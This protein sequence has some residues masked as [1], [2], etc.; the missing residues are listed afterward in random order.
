MKKAILILLVVSLS[1]LFFGCE[2]K[3]QDITGW[4][5]FVEDFIAI[6]FELNPTDAVDAG[7][8]Q[9]DGEFPDLSP[10]GIQTLI[11]WLHVQKDSLQ[12]YKDD[13]PGQF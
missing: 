3:K 1:F 13:V 7:L 8:H 12:K 6:Y 9:Y 4:G 10:D 11:D 2:E 5:S